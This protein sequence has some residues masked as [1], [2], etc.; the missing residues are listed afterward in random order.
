MGHFGSSEGVSRSGGYLVPNAR[1]KHVLEFYP[2]TVFLSLCTGLRG[3]WFSSNDLGLQILS[4][5]A[6]DAIFVA[7]Y[8]IPGHFVYF[9]TTLICCFLSLYAGFPRILLLRNDLGW[10]ILSLCT[11]FRGILLTLKR[12]W[13]F[14]RCMQD[15]R[16]F[17]LLRNDL[18][19]QILSLYTGLR[20]ICLTLKRPWIADFVAVYVTPGIRL[21]SKRHS[22]ADFVVVY[23]TPGPFAYFETTLDSDFVGIY[24]IPWR[25]QESPGEPRRAQDSA[26]EPRSPQEPR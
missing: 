12:P 20:G 26:G 13:R 1:T 22:I 16:A 15:S 14:C 2:L 18:G 9:E 3:I 6:G 25:A 17:C 19:L 7:V 21:T 23:G 24:G 4:L 5:Y 8:R 10:L 11:G